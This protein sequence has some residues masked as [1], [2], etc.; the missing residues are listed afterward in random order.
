MLRDI[1]GG[2]PYKVPILDLD[3]FNSPPPLFFFAF[4]ALLFHICS[5]FPWNAI[6]FI[7]RC[8]GVKPGLKSSI[9]IR[10]DWC[11][12]PYGRWRVFNTKGRKCTGPSRPPVPRGKSCENDSND[13]SNHFWSFSFSWTEDKVDSSTV[14]YAF[15]RHIETVFSM[16]PRSL[17]IVYIKLTV[18]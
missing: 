15:L 12:Q 11:P 3:F 9:L 4:I 5:T 14:L 16:V 17:R 10:H 7:W 1:P 13:T 8:G 6:Y 18:E 2:T